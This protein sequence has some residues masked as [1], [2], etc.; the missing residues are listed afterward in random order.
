MKSVNVAQNLDAVHKVHE[1]GLFADNHDQFDATHVFAHEYSR[2]VESG[3]ILNRPHINV[4]YQVLHDSAFHIDRERLQYE[5]RNQFNRLYRYYGLQNT[6]MARWI[7]GSATSSGVFVRITKAITLYPT[8][9]YQNKAI[10]GVRGTWSRRP[11]G[12]NSGARGATR[13]EVLH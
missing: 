7:R 1:A 8:Q 4:T 12:V 2:A 11:R 6:D 9:E 10:A 5:F 3:E 13:Q